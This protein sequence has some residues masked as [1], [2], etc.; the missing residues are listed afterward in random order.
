[1]NCASAVNIAARHPRKD[2]VL[3]RHGCHRFRPETPRPAQPDAVAAPTQAFEVRLILPGHLPRDQVRFEEEGSQA[4]NFAIW[5]RF[6]AF[7]SAPLPN[8][9]PVTKRRKTPL[10]HK[11]RPLRHKPPEKLTL[12]N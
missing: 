8:Q 12:R 10:G 4:L 7:N 2:S 11:S 6:L 1:M 3:Q 5:V 9:L